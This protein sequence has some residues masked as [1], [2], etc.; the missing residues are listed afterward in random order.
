MGSENTL[1]KQVS[2]IVIPSK[3]SGATNPCC[4]NDMAM[5]NVSFMPQFVIIS[6]NC[7]K[8][9]SSLLPVNLPSFLCSEVEYD[10]VVLF[11]FVYSLLV[12]SAPFFALNSQVSSHFRPGGGCDFCFYIFV[13]I[14]AEKIVEIFTIL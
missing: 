10:A 6:S 12:V 5:S 3:A 9:K 4:A 11:C 14:S 13:E 8:L 2:H 1:L 7:F